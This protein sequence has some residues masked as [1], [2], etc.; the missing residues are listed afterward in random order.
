MPHASRIEVEGKVLQLIVPVNMLP[1]V[2][3]LRFEIYQDIAY[4]ANDR[5]SKFHAVHQLLRYINWFGQVCTF[6][7]RL[8]DAELLTY[9]DGVFITSSTNNDIL[10]IGLRQRKEI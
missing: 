3:G 1:N 10:P 5:A 6:G 9:F 2:A 8:Y 4:L 7:D